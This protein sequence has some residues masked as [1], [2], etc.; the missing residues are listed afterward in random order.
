[1]HPGPK[2]PPNG[3][4]ALLPLHP[5]LRY[6]LP[7]MPLL[8]PASILRKGRWTIILQLRLF[9]SFSL[10][11]TFMSRL[12]C[13]HKTSNNALC[14]PAS[15]HQA[16]WE[17]EKKK[18]KPVVLSYKAFVTNIWSDNKRCCRLS[19]NNPNAGDLTFSYTWEFCSRTMY[20]TTP[21]KNEWKS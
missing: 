2:H 4:C 10:R 14:N 21:P 11:G 16:G 12:L 13:S 5:I 19:H 9:R 6:S 1:M 20:P 18:K 17:V 7:V 8:S 3:C 15:L